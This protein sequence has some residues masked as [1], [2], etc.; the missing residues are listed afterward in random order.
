MIAKSATSA[1]NHFSYSE[2]QKKLSQV[3]EGFSTG[4]LLYSMQ[5]TVLHSAPQCLRQPNMLL[6]Y[7]GRVIIWSATVIHA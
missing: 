6:I 5:I 3:S 1:E 4:L 7:G 2:Q